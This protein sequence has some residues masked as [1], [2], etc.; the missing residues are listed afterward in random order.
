MMD[1]VQWE[2]IE[3]PKHGVKYGYCEECLFLEPL[4][5]IRVPNQ[6]RVLPVDKEMFPWMSAYQVESTDIP[7]L[8]RHPVKR[9]KEEE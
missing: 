8:E 6:Y 4:P 5:P 3:C 9:K 7:G 1:H 2:R